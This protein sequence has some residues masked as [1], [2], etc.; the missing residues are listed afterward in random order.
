MLIVIGDHQVPNKTLE[1]VY[2]H[3]FA[4]GPASTKAR[5]FQ[6]YLGRL[7]LNVHVPDLNGENFE[8]L[9][10]T[11]QLL[12][13]DRLFQE[14]VGESDALLM[15]SSMGGL[16]SVLAQRHHKNVR[17]MILLAP[18]FGLNRRWHEL[19]GQSEL[20]RWR[21]EGSIEVF[22]YLYSKHVPLKY[23]FIQDA[24]NYST[25]DLLVS[26]PTLVI[27]GLADTV[28]PP[29]ESENF[30]RHNPDQVEL[31]LLKSDHCLTDVL[32]EM[33]LIVENFLNVHRLLPG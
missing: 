15:G 16:L 2:L 29:R 28:V 32:D 30:Y 22:H 10:L 26:V 20:Q 17:A 1:C 13:I 5:H 6:N 23:E 3:G 7:G 11:G 24:E 21:E 8:H 25:D 12:I 9:T 31:H 27:H 18:G 14:S 4:S 19:L 33:S